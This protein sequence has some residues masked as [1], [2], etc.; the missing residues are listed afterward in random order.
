MRREFRPGKR[1]NGI[2]SGFTLLE[3]LLAVAILGMAYL[4]V[5]QNFSISLRNIDRLGRGN[6]RDFRGLLSLESDLRPFP[7]K[8]DVS[9]PLEGEFFLAGQ[10]LQLVWVAGPEGSRLSALMLERK[11]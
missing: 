6:L 2:D 1:R 11:P 4:A 3:I 7:D 5:L 10:R 9:D 8:G